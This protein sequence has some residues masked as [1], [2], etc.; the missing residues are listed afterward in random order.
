VRR[1]S[2]DAGQDQG[3]KGLSEARRTDADE[4][5]ARFGRRALLSAAGAGALALA[6]PARPLGLGLRDAAALPKKRG[7]FGAR[8]PIPRVL[9]DADLQLDIREAQI[10]IMPGPR[11]PMWTYGGS[12]PGPTIR[13]PAGQR[14]RVTF[15][16]RLPPSAGELTV[17]LHGGHNTSA[18]DGQPG[19]L[20]AAQPRSAYCVIS[21]RLSARESGNDLLIAPGAQRTYTYD[22]VEDGGPERAA[23][24]WYHDHRLD[25]TALNVWRGLAGM[26]ILDDD[27]DAA[28]PLPRG[29]R[30]IPLMI[31]DRA[32]DRHNR[33]TDPFGSFAHAPNDGVTGRYVLVNGAHLPHHRVAGQRYRL[34]VLNA[35]NFRSYNLEL[36]NGCA[37]VQIATESGLM[38]APIKRRRVLLGPGER[39]ELIVDFRPSAGE[40]VELR[41]VLRRHGPDKLGSR[42]YVGPL[43]EFRVGKRR[44]DSTR[45][46]RKLRPL[47]SWAA[48]ASRTPSHRWVVSIGGGLRPAWLINGRTFDPAYADAFPA[49]GTTQTWELHNRTAVAHLLH[50]HNT[51]WYMLSRNGRAPAPWEACLKET[52]FLDPGD[53]VVVAGHFSDHLG[54]FVVHCHMIDHED[55]GLMSQFEVVAAG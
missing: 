33:L 32:F 6:L 54:K 53:R 11:T 5:G 45:V 23:L 36:S 31:T 41:S 13:R 19:G 46:P 3:R 1:A 50:L 25:R 14:T 29:E 18:D 44:P 40:R 4:Q 15:R 55:H 9:T 20:T 17:H 34:R 8:L 48:N 52:F 49:L 39:A 7:R 35:S 37:M 30:D 24:Q 42:P 28:L 27:V 10:P 16:H 38:P 12:F 43:M 22:L 21:P 47:P 26:W 2:G 51:D